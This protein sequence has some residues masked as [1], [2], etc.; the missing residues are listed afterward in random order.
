MSFVDT[1]LSTSRLVQRRVKLCT[2]TGLERQLLN[3]LESL[4]LKFNLVSRGKS[5]VDILTGLDTI[6]SIIQ[7]SRI[8]RQLYIHV[9]DPFDAENPKHFVNRL[10]QADWASFIP[11]SHKLPPPTIKVLSS[12]SKLYH[13]GM[14]RNMVERVINSHCYRYKKMQGDELPSFMKNRGYIPLCPKIT[15]DINNNNCQVLADASG[16]LSERPWNKLSIMDDRMVSSA[17]SAVIQE[18]ITGDALSDSSQTIFFLSLKT[19]MQFIQIKQIR[20]LGMLK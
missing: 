15:V 18:L 19:K 9:L 4:S 2:C 16:D 5:Y 14:V 17:S 13:T 20:N 1:L 6:W 11:F 3:E 8:C 7:N 10:N 12:N